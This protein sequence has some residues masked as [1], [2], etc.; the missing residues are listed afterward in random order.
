MVTDIAAIIT[1]VAKVIKVVV[2]LTP[3]II[4]TVD[5]AKPF[6][7]AIIEV[8]KGH[9]ITE[10]QLKELEDRIDDLSNQLMKPLPPEEE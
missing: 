7:M 6:A 3:T 1:T 9:K 4:K 5:D 8:L 2:D 10:E